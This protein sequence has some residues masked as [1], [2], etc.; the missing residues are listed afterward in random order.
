MVKPTHSTNWIYI[1]YLLVSIGSA[2]ALTGST[3]LYLLQQGNLFKTHY[4]TYFLPILFVG[5][6]TLCSGGLIFVILHQEHKQETVPPLFP[7]SPPPPPP[8]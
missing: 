1:G 4:S 7:E 3:S 5:I 6:A 8:E 2:L